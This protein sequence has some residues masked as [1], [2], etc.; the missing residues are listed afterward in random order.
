MLQGLFFLP[1]CLVAIATA[2]K[3]LIKVIC[4]SQDH[5]LQNDDSFEKVL[6]GSGSQRDF[7]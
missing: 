1:Y 6:S 2:K 4:R 7:L 5:P 3:L